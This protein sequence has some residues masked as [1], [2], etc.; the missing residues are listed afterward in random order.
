MLHDSWNHLVSDFQDD[1]GGD[2]SG[3]NAGPARGNDHVHF[4]LNRLGQCIAQCTCVVGENNILY[5]NG[6]GPPF[7]VLAE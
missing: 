3:A 4:S 6:P 7:K 5:L 2:I 1:I